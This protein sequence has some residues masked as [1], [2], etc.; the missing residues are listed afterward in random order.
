LGILEDPLPILPLFLVYSQALLVNPIDYSS[1]R[2]D[3]V[4][5]PHCDMNGMNGMKS[6]K[7]GLVGAKN[8]QT[9]AKNGLRTRRKRAS[10]IPL[11]GA[12]TD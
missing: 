6:A 2:L 5:H 4:A 9:G 12:R 7:N 3:D 8:G 10:A 1:S 11:P